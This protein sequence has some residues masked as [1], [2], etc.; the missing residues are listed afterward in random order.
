MTQRRGCCRSTRSGIVA[1]RRSWREI[2]P[3][4]TG[5]RQKERRR[6]VETDAADG[7]PLTTRIPTAA[8][9][10]Q[11]AFHSSHQA[12]RRTLREDLIQHMKNSLNS[13]STCLKVVDTRRYGL[14]MPFGEIVA[15]WAIRS[16]K[17]RALRISGR[18]GQGESFAILRLSGSPQADLQCVRS[19]SFSLRPLR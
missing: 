7:N 9:K 13:V 17:G 15:N 10:A 12:R 4:K 6:P 5:D 2:F 19:P 16:L 11:N 3:W 14:G 8:W 18:T 1:L